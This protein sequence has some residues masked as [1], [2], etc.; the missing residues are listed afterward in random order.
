M[1]TINYSKNNNIYN[2][3]N[4][5]FYINMFNYSKNNI[6]FNTNNNIF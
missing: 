5:I 3:N 2:M 6:I 1:N 4:T